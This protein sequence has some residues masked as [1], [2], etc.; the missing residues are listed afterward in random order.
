MTNP[1]HT[2]DS[3]EHGTPG[4][5]V[6]L[7]RYVSSDGIGTDPFSSNYWNVHSVRARTF[8]DKEHDGLTGIWSGFCLVNPP[9]G[10]TKMVDGKRV[11]VTPSLVRPAWER[12]VNDWRRGVIDGALWVS[13]S[14]EQL[15]NLQGS[16]AHPLQLPTVVPC[17]RLRYLK[18]PPGGGPPV[19]GTAPT[20]ASALTLLP[21]R[22]DPELARAQMRRFV[23]AGGK[24]GAVVRPL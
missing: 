11:I 21:S 10:V 17:E 23:E 1:M 3:C 12:L 4:V 15:C 18:R 5:G 14:L 16:P 13:F 9:G 8:Y 19:P 22:R 20:H 24:L 6:E 2:S 7:A